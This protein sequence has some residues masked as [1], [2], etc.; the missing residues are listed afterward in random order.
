MA[1]P[2]TRKFGQFLV[3]LETAP[4][5]GVFAAPCGFTSKSFGLT[6]STNRQPIPDCDDPDA[7]IWNGS[8]KSAREVRVQG[9]GVMA[10][11]SYEDW[12]AAF[13][14]D[15]AIL[16]RVEIS[17]TGAEGAGYWQGP[18]NVT[19]L[20]HTASFGNKVELSISGENDGAWVWVDAA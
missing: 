8:E 20:S 3:K 6:A 1:Q 4:G 14:S 19:E 2:T 7:P 18:L 16:A 13:L 5:S 15:V 11:E 17:G 12:R 9:S 10:L